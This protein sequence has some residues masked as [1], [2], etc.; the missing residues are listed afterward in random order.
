MR[1]LLRTISPLL[2]ASLLAACSGGGAS[3]PA[4]SNGSTTTASAARSTATAAGTT[5]KMSEDGHRTD[6]G[7]GDHYSSPLTLDTTSL[8]F[9]SP[10]APAQTFSVTKGSLS[11]IK[12]SIANSNVATVAPVATAKKKKQ[13]GDDG[14]DG[15]HHDGG[16]DNW[17]VAFFSSFDDGHGDD[18]DQ[19]HKSGKFAVTPVG[20]GS[21]IVKVVLSVDDDKNVEVDIP[22]TV[23]GS[24]VCV[25]SKAVTCPTPIP[26]VTPT[27]TPTPTPAP[28]PTPTL[29]PT[30]GPLVAAFNGP[31]V[32]DCGLVACL[33][34]GLPIIGGTALYPP[35]VVNASETK[36]SGLF[37]VTFQYSSCGIAGTTGLVANLTAALAGSF[38][39]VP[40]ASGVANPT[41]H[42]KTSNGQ[43]SCI[44][45]V[46]DDHGG[47]ILLNGTYLL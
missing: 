30:P 26:V 45:V 33:T 24:A 15:D 27:P 46:S 8:S 28:K 9:D 21:T 29:A 7:D 37:T 41:G 17:F 34:S 47:S 23:A 1:R 38:N 42:T 19:A 14:G 18:G 20:A 32:I 35:F 16:G 44:F 31:S 2:I 5:R 6:G 11:H 13:H 4:S 10:T 43:I 40:T 12:V 3:A 39:V 36:Y 22:V 25:P